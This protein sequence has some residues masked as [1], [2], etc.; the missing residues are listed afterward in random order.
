MKASQEKPLRYVIES[1]YNA[2]SR[3]KRFD[4]V[5]E[6]DLDLAEILESKRPSNEWGEILTPFLEF[7]ADDRQNK[8]D[9]ER[10]KR[11]R[12]TD[13]AVEVIEEAEE[14]EFKP[15]RTLMT[16]DTEY[17]L[18]R[19]ITLGMTKV[20]YCDP[21]SDVINDPTNIPSE[22]QKP[23]PI[24]RPTQQI[25]NGALVLGSH[26]VRILLTLGLETTCVLKNGKVIDMSENAL[27]MKIIKDTKEGY[28][29]LVDE[30]LKELANKV[31]EAQTELSAE[32]A[33]LS[34][35]IDCLPERSKMFLSNAVEAHSKFR[36]QA[37][38][39]YIHIN[40]LTA[41]D[42]P[43]S[44]IEALQTRELE[45]Y[46]QE[47][48]MEKYKRDMKV[49]NANKVLAQSRVE[50]RMDKLLWAKTEFEAKLRRYFN[51]CHEQWS[52]SA[53][54][55]MMM[56]VI[57]PGPT[58]MLGGDDALAQLA[59]IPTPPAEEDPF[60]P[61]V[62]LSPGSTAPPANRH[63]PPL[64]ADMQEFLVYARAARMHTETETDVKVAFLDAIDQ[65][66]AS[67]KVMAGELAALEIE[68]AGLDEGV[69]KTAKMKDILIRK[70]KLRKRIETLG[71]LTRQ[72]D[73]QNLLDP[74]DSEDSGDKLKELA[75]G[76]K[77]LEQIKTQQMNSKTHQENARLRRDALEHQIRKDEQKHEET[78]VKSQQ[79]E[80]DKALA[81]ARSTTEEITRL[82]QGAVDLWTVEVPRLLSA[83]TAM[84]GGLPLD[85]EPDM[86][87][88]MADR[89][90]DMTVTRLLQMIE[91]ECM[92]FCEKNISQPVKIVERLDSQFTRSA[93]LNE[94]ARDRFR[95]EWTGWCGKLKDMA[96]GFE[97]QTDHGI[98]NHSSSGLDS[99]YQ[100]M[101][102]VKEELATCGV[103]A[104][105]VT[106]QGVPR[107]NLTA[108]TT[109]MNALVQSMQASIR[110]VHLKHTVLTKSLRRIFS[111]LDE[112]E[113]DLELDGPRDLPDLI[114]DARNECQ[115]VTGVLELMDR[116]TDNDGVRLATARPSFVVTLFTD[117]ARSNAA[118]RDTPVELYI[119]FD[120]CVR[121]GSD[122]V[123]PEERARLQDYLT[124]DLAVGEEAE[125]YG[126]NDTPEAVRFFTS[127]PLM[128]WRWL[129]SR[130]FTKRILPIIDRHATDLKRLNE[131]SVTY[132]GNFMHPS[133][134]P[135]SWLVTKRILLLYMALTAGVRQQFRTLME[136]K[137]TAQVKI[138]QIADKATQGGV[139]RIATG[140]TSSLVQVFADCLGIHARMVAM[141]R[142]IDYQC[143]LLG[144]MMLGHM[145][146]GAGLDHIVD[147]IFDGDHL[148]SA[149]K[150]IYHKDTVWKLNDIDKFGSPVQRWIVSLI[151]RV[152][153][154]WEHE[155]TVAEFDEF[156]DTIRALDTLPDIDNEFR[157][158]PGELP[159]QK[160][161]PR[162]DPSNHRALWDAIR[163][164]V[165]ETSVSPCN[166][167]KLAGID[168]YTARYI[169]PWKS[170]LKGEFRPTNVRILAQDTC[171]VYKETTV[172]TVQD[173]GQVLNTEG[174]NIEVPPTTVQ[175][176][177]ERFG[178]VDVDKTA[179]EY[180]TNLWKL[181][182]LGPVVYTRNGG[183]IRFLTGDLDPM[184]TQPMNGQ[185][186]MYMVIPSTA[187]GMDSVLVST[188]VV[189]NVLFLQ[190]GGMADCVLIFA[191]DG[192]GHLF[193]VA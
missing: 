163:T 101:N 117:M 55:C 82:K 185:R 112:I 4:T 31:T 183:N 7:S 35:T 76:I 10:A 46:E 87:R 42:E 37:K 156:K 179:G 141:H 40:R 100:T 53:E 184:P 146:H 162:E 102:E 153:S 89:L 81:N 128:M 127:V 176:A 77:T 120:Q 27:T 28:R 103:A 62:P 171:T 143:K 45:L 105:K 125:P 64:S 70:E 69:T 60:P 122:A 152:H 126:N 145:K 25:C 49:Y 111:R 48:K 58:G 91:D 165:E 189:G 107:Y 94:E 167:G 158:A 147:F 13:P 137:K 2:S 16:S 133:Q 75:T 24:P 144:N 190:T 123:P 164:V 54:K 114:I 50:Q 9:K 15:I 119:L 8:V 159:Q 188:A 67:I 157:R 20:Y 34:T 166:S 83:F 161:L 56:P 57:T 108:V 6:R 129:P 63:R 22:P 109:K 3:S 142:S 134:S 139:D 187:Y 98:N 38:E 41:K 78:R 168:L 65:D 86:R 32:A 11:V 74:P 30:R 154:V 59:S 116:C 66:R 36:D 130:V 26:I 118:E 17:P 178:V 79:L 19:W 155:T 92:S 121:A 23:R 96:M 170:L 150:R 113:R 71:E 124:G 5:T 180:T 99:V 135:Q 131:L 132:T 106:E 174:M 39:G 149:I 110:D 85:S 115:R 138:Q 193:Y 151:G 175:V 160:R 29:T 61:L 95:K 93:R 33:A 173:T 84:T 136:D 43:G 177:I 21:V 191:D 148:H 181:R 14:D 192:R 73:V 1:A 90:S 18:G 52:F 88:R 44:W 104:M 169:E 12:F 172:N 68:T 72:G 80:L 182:Y 97:D 140:P 186:K 51:H 47:G